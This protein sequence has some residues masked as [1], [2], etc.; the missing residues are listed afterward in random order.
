MYSGSQL[1]HHVH[2]MIFAWHKGAFSLR[3]REALI[4]ELQP[5]TALIRRLLVSLINRF[6]NLRWPN[7]SDHLFDAKY[8][9]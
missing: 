9:S 6:Q 7:L 2:W 1:R 8:F 4:A 5:L 3:N